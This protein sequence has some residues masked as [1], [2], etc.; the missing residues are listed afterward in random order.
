MESTASKNLSI[1]DMIIHVGAYLFKGAPTASV[2][3]IDTQFLKDLL[4][5][6]D[7]EIE[8]RQAQTQ[9]TRH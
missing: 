1:E 5:L 4:L 9:V 3:Q 6:L 2:T 8:R 7:A